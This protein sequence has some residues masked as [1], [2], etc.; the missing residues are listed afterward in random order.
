MMEHDEWGEP[1]GEAVGFT[2][3]ADRGMGEWVRKP[4]REAFL[5]RDR[6][7]RMVLEQSED[8]AIKHAPV[9]AT[10]YSVFMGL[11]AWTNDMQFRMPCTI[12][13]SRRSHPEHDWSE[14]GWFSLKELRERRSS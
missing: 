3:E 10:H 7:L 8:H 9:G 12:R 13:Y 4:R 5:E 14:S 1:V 11:P 2:F 6:Q